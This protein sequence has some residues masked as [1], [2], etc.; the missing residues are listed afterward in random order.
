MA[1][2]IIDNVPVYIVDLVEMPEL[3]VV[4]TGFE[5]YYAQALTM[6][7]QGGLITEPGK[8]GIEVNFSDFTWK[9]YGITE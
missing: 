6:A 1:I 3:P 2:Q 8:Y 4:G 9:V 7:I 5:Q